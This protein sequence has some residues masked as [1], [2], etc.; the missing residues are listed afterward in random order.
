VPALDRSKIMG[1]Q[2]HLELAIGEVEADTQR[3]QCAQSVE[4]TPLTAFPRAGALA[5][6]RP[7][8]NQNDGGEGGGSLRRG[9]GQ[10]FR[11]SGKGAAARERVRNTWL[12]E[13]LARASQEII[14]NDDQ[15]SRR[16][17]S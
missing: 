8:A 13:L 10:D 9:Y 3:E 12:T 16:S 11:R 14:Q 15:D 7:P 5:A 6:P 1:E 4:A 2:L 17:G